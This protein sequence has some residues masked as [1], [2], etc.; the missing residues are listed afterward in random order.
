MG[1][2]LTFKGLSYSCTLR[3]PNTFAFQRQR[4]LGE[5]ASMFHYTFI[6]CL[7]VVYSHLLSFRPKLLKF[8]S[9]KYIHHL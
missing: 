9:V 5:C 6:I 2:N 1:F 4:Y 3:M 8:G 7:D